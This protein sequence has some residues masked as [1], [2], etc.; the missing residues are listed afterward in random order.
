M[1]PV[2]FN[3]GPVEV[4]SYAV[5]VLL[6]FVVAGAVRRAELARL[7]HAR[8]P[9]YRWVPV[10]ALLGAV[11]G[12]KLGMLLFEPPEVAAETF[13]RVLSLDFTGKTVVGGLIGGYLGVEIAKKAVG[14]T[15][16]TG[17]GFAV[18]VPLAQAVGRVGC[19]LNG[20]CYGTPWEGP[21]AVSIGGVWRHPT[22]LYEAGLDLALAA[23]L[24]AT[25]WTERP[26]GHLFRRYLVGYALIRFATEFVRGD[27]GH[28]LGPLTWVQ[29]LCLGVAALF[30]GLILRGEVR[31]SP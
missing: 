4:R 6:A 2:L 8:M 29:A 7:G 22:Q 3:L 17:D 19:L 10:G 13:A 9:G 28:T 5:F 14:I 16:S 27:A 11:V 20:C 26:A 31:R 1:H 12:A 23:A 15:R 18:A 24:W 30:G 25:R 21:W